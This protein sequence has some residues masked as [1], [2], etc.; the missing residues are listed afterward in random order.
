MMIRP[1]GARLFLIRR[2]NTPTSEA[3]GFERAESPGVPLQSRRWEPIG[4]K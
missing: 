1:R 3:F 4:V 2:M